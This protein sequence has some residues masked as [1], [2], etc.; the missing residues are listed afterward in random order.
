M[1]DDMRHSG[2]T[3]LTITYRDSDYTLRCVDSLLKEG[4]C[5][6]LVVDN[7]ADGGKTAAELKE[8]MRH[9]PAA[10]VLVTDRNV[11]FARAVN[12]GLKWLDEN[13]PGRLVCLL[14]NDARLLDGAIERMRAALQQRPEAAIAFPT[15][16]NDGVATGPLHYN[17]IFG[18][19]HR[20][21]AACS[22]P[23]ATGCCMLIDPSKTGIPLFDEDFFL[24][25]E[26]VELAHR[27]GPERYVHVPETLVWHA[28][29]ASSGFASDTYEF[30]TVVS[31]WLLARKLSRSRMEFALYLAGR[32]VAL[33]ARALLRSWR[34]RSP[35]P[36]KA[37]L[38]GTRRAIEDMYSAK[39]ERVDG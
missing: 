8:I 22:M 15:V 20:K 1:H 21:K 24:Y 18:T 3:G 33:P 13:F 5:H 35:V 31:H 2:V 12:L 29:S 16:D 36:L 17:S 10:T 11:G 23:Y 28:G 19:I 34:Y 30:N 7:S 6:V 38:A 25:G 32:A 4:A 39:V 9:N 14:N 26:D 37:F 27:L